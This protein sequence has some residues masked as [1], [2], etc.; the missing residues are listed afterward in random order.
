MFQDKLLVK[1]VEHYINPQK[2]I[3]IAREFIEGASFNIY[4]NLRYY[5]GRGKDLKFYME[6][7][8]EL[9]RQLNEVTNVEELMG[10]EGNIRKLL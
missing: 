9:R 4:R 3:E 6:Q 2:R 7:I 8:E 5:N 10:Y 1:Q